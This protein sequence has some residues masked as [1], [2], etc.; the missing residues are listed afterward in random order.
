MLSFVV[1]RQNVKQ[2]EKNTILVEEIR[3][4]VN[5]LLS[6]QKDDG[7]FGDPNPVLHRQTL[8]NSSKGSVNKVC[9]LEHVETDDKLK[10][11]RT[12]LGETSILISV[13]TL[14]KSFE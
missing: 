10:E 11:K 9:M 1:Q 6:I 3:K 14:S 13:G 8:V 5:Y 12:P 4:P 2:R 7:S